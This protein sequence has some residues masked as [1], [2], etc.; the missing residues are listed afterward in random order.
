MIGKSLRSA[1]TQIAMGAM[2][3][4][5]MLTVY[6]SMQSRSPGA[7]PGCTAST[8]QRHLLSTRSKPGRGPRAW[9]CGKTVRQ[10]RRG[11]G[12]MPAATRPYKFRQTGLAFVARLASPVQPSALQKRTPALHRNQTPAGRPS[13]LLSQRLLPVPSSLAYGPCR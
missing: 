3:A 4:K 5:S 10:F 12:A 2:F 6:T 11:I 13:D 9:V 7:S 8:R 1:Q